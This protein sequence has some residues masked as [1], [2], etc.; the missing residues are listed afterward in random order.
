[1]AAL[2]QGG[3]GQTETDVGFD[4]AWSFFI[5]FQVCMIGSWATG[6]NMYVLADGS[7]ARSANLWVSS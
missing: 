2:D 5:R 7:M 1:M 3:R 6:E 4:T